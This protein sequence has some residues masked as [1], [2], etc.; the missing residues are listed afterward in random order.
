MQPQ[1]RTRAG[2]VVKLVTIT[3]LVLVSPSVAAAQTDTPVPRVT[4]LVWG[5]EAAATISA[6]DDSGFFNYTD[7]EHDT[8]RQLRLRLM[9][10]LRLPGR[11]ALL[12]E[13]RGQNRQVDAPVLFIRWQPWET[14]SLHLQ[15]GRIPSV[16]GAFARRAYGADN[17]LAGVPLVYQYL[18]SLRP[19]ALPAS[20]DDVLRMRARGW[21][22]SYPIGSTALA[23]GLP[24]VAFSRGDTGV[25]GQWTT[26]QWSLAGALTLGTAADPRIRNNNDG[27]S[28]SGRVAMVRPSGVTVGISV[29]R[30]AWVG[31]AVA[32]ILQA[33]DRRADAAQTLV[34]VD[35]EMARGHW[36]VRGEWWRSQFDVPTLSQSLVAS[37]SFLETRYRVRPRWQVAGRVD[38][39]TFSTIRG[40]AGVATPWDA[41][42]W[43]LE[44][45]V[46][47]R[48][49]RHLELRAGWQHNWRSAGRVRERS[50]P[51]LQALYWF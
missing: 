27:V 49:S 51:T 40:A 29:A 2:Q 30:G 50:F 35:A 24:L 44:G 34:G 4:G 47:Y 43:R 12:G 1:M 11:V 13:V 17:L 25:Q 18:T 39:L 10:E 41:P 20:P 48:A 31:D 33:S 5:G 22:P 37:A 46:G 19:D 14:R 16:I 6:R 28:V 8:L 21:R 45:V 42:V 9:G 3:A 26:A 36:I 15:A 32:S 23:P 7:Y 38:Q